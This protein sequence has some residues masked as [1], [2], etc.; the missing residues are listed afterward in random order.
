MNMN[1]LII[2]GAGGFG[3]EVHQWLEDW[4]ACHEGWVI[5]GFIDDLKKDLGDK[6]G[7]SPILSTI[8]AYEP[9]PDEY[10][11]CAIGIP[12]GKRLVVEKLKSKGGRFFTLVH[13]KAI[14]GRNVVIGEGTIVCPLSTLTVDI[15]VGPFV[16]VNLS[17][18]VGHDARIGG[19]VTL[20]PHCDVNGN[21]TLDEEVFV[22]T[23]AT[24]IPGIHVGEKAII[25]AGSVVVRSVSPGQTVLGIPAKRISG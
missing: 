19:F 5:A 25:G 17:C 3:R 6:K 23:G 8:D 15:E 7:Y 20:S 14:V 13:P 24:M 22:G 2:V 1:K 16:T 18:T 9:G 21:V 4:V 12:S 10:L 11:V